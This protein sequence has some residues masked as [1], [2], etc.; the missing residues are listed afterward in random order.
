MN[1]D[2]ISSDADAS[3]LRNICCGSHVF[4]I[5]RH[6]LAMI[7][8][9]TADSANLTSNSSQKK[10]NQLNENLSQSSPEEQ[11]FYDDEDDEPSRKPAPLPHQSQN[12]IYQ[13]GSQFP[14]SIQEYRCYD[15]GFTFPVNQNEGSADSRLIQDVI[16][17]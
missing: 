13:P 10:G 17:F 9:K 16:P 15:G 4:I 2:I 5:T 1:F 6:L 12:N 7:K 8:R 14:E 11:A 3:N